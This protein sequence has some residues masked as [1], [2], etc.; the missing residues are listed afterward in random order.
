MK[1]CSK[2]P[3][4]HQSKMVIGTLATTNTK[5]RTFMRAQSRVFLEPSFCLCDSN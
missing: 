3:Y 4:T 2:V 1:S 5:E